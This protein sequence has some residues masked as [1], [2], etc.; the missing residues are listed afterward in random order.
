ME[1]L[2][3][4]LFLP[5]GASSVALEID[6][7]HVF[8]ISVTML[9]STGVFL[10]GIVFMWRY[11]R[12]RCGPTTA[13]I[14]PPLTFEIAIIGG[15]LSLFLLWWVIGFQQYKKIRIPPRDALVMHVVAK[16]WMWQFADESGRRSQTVLVVPQDRPVRLVMTSRDV[17][18]SLFIPAFRVKQDLLPGRYTEMWFEAQKAGAYDVYCAEYCGL[19]HSRMRAT[20]VVLEPSD[21]ERYLEGV[22]PAEV[23]EAEAGNSAVGEEE[24]SEIGRR[25]AVRAGCFACHTVSGQ[26]HIAPSWRGLYGSVRELADGRRIRADEAYLTRSMME[27]EREVVRGFDSV[28][29]SFRGV[30]DASET[31]AVVEYI[32]TLR[33]PATEPPRVVLPPVIAVPDSGASR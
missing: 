7:L 6:L 24:L 32:R 33:E 30:L 10:A 3:R 25:V 18:H 11:H 5:N 1:L 2:R 29:P 4:V 9:G 28:M 19:N 14:T 27:P 16:Q 21:Y 23:Q 31:A 15:L 8:V 26:S 17:I 12:S 22:I 13:T 20:V